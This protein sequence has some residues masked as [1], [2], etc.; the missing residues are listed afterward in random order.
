MFDIFRA[1]GGGQRLGR[2]EAGRVPAG[3]F[4]GQRGAGAQAGSVRRQHRRGRR[5]T[6]VRDDGGGRLGRCARIEERRPR[7]HLDGIG[8]I[9]RQCDPRHSGFSTRGQPV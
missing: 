3:E 2:Y 1:R 5:G 4:A 8:W 7:S 6:T 9:G